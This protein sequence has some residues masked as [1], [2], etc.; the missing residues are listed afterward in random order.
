MAMD[1]ILFPPVI[2]AFT[3]FMLTMIEGVL[4]GFSLTLNKGL[5]QTAVVQQ[6]LSQL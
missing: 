1:Q 6:S 4:S 5:Q 3:F 2:T